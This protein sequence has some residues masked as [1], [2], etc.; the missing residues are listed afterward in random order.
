MLSLEKREKHLPGQ[1]SGGQ[2]REPGYFEVHQSEINAV[3]VHV[4]LG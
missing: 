2:Q 3:A 4:V 1:M